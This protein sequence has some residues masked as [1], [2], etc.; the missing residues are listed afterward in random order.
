VI[1]RRMEMSAR[2]LTGPVVGED[3]YAIPL[4]ITQWDE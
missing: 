4:A 3:H 2:G 1:V